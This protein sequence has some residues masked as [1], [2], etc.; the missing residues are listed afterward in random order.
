MEGGL[1]A[2]ALNATLNRYRAVGDDVWEEEQVSCNSF[3]CVISPGY[4]FPGAWYTCPNSD[5]LGAVM[6][7]TMIRSYGKSCSLNKEA[8]RVVNLGFW[9]DS[10]DNVSTVG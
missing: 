1:E 4:S 6:V 8:S 7:E 2:A 10:L 9:H 3:S 5:T